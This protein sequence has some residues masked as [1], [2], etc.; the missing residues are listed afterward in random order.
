MGSPRVNPVVV[1]IDGSSSALD[2]ARW[3]AAEAA[4]RRTWLKIVFADVFA[5]VYLPELPTIPLPE[6]Y[7]NAMARQA[8]IWLDRAEQEARSAATDVEVRTTCRTGSAAPVLIDESR[9]AQ[10]VVVGSRGLGGYTGLI[11]GSVAV[12]LCAHGHCPVA[13]V[14]QP[15]TEVDPAAPV[16]VGVDG[17]GDQ[18]PVLRTAF[19]AAAVRRAMLIAVHAWHEVGSQRAW[20]GFRA[21]DQAD[22]V[23]AEEERFL[24]ETMAGWADKY[25]DVAVR[26]VVVHDQPAR[27]LLDHANRAQLVV[28]GSRGRGGFAGLLLGS[29]SQQL[30]HHAPCPVLVVR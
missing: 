19:D 4:R 18:D 26:H 17:R 11:V 8:R 27:A 25:Q 5:L 12:A 1:G 13:V 10:L 6:T 24:A 16:V 14:R 9:R 23:Q 20:K 30:V 21:Q 7:S 28:V 2:A 29:T 3:A 22:A 15:P